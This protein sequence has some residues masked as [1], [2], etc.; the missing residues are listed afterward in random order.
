MGRGE[1]GPVLVMLPQAPKESS[2]SLSH[3]KNL[4]KASL[5]VEGWAWQGLTGHRHLLEA[6]QWLGIGRTAW[7][8]WSGCLGHQQ[9]PAESDS[10]QVAG[11]K[12]QPQWQRGPATHTSGQLHCGCRVPRTSVVRAKLWPSFL[13]L[14]GAALCLPPQGTP[15]SLAKPDLSF[16][17]LKGPVHK[18]LSHSCKHR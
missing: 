4:R 13:V 17:S 16:L 6:T 10:P 8:S 18:P 3:S 9:G 11:A 15:H 1:T 2:S 14:E 7:Q 12:C 5:G